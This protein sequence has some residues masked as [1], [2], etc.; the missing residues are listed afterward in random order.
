MNSFLNTYILLNCNEADKRK[1]KDE[2][3]AKL[4]G[5]TVRSWKT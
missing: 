1:Q 2:D 4:L 3:I 5:V